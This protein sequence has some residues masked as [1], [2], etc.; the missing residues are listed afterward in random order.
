MVVEYMYLVV[1][2][3]WGWQFFGG[4]GGHNAEQHLSVKP[5][6]DL[7]ARQT[8]PSECLGTV[9]GEA[10][11]SPPSLGPGLATAPAGSGSVSFTALGKVGR[12]WRAAASAPPTRA[13]EA[14]RFLT[15]IAVRV[16]AEVSVSF[17][18]P[19]Y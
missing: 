11:I 9:C 4:L 14:Q 15:S 8:S 7:N 5:Y 13:S 17:P 6:W 16:A 10:P 18:S 19:D 1:V 12:S 3:T 2:V